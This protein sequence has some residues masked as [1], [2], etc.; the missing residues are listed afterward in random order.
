MANSMK[1]SKKYEHLYAVVRYDTDETTPID[2]RFFIVKV[3]A[4]RQYADEEAKRL[5]ALNKKKGYYYFVQIAR[6][7]GAPIET[8]ALVMKETALMGLIDQDQSNKEEKL[9]P[10]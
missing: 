8:T 6:Y 9:A 10:G 4:D 2:L 1:P 7:E 5:F 3:V